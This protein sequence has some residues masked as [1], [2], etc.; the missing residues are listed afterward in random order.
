MV[1]QLQTGGR[2]RV[3]MKSNVWDGK[4]RGDKAIFSR[5]PFT[6][7]LMLSAGGIGMLLPS[8]LSKVLPGLDRIGG[9]IGALS[10]AFWGLFI[11]A[12]IVAAIIIFRQDELAATVVFAVSIVLDF[13]LG[14][15]IV[16]LLMA[17]VLLLIFFLARSPRYPWAEPGALWLWALFLVLII[18]AAIR[19]APSTYEVLYYYSYNTLGT[20]VMFWLGT[21]IARRVTSVRRF[22]NLLAGFGTL[23]AIHAL[24][25][26]TTGIF[27]FWA[28]VNSNYVASLS[29][30]I[31]IP[32]LDVHRVGSFFLNPD[33]A[34]P[35]FAAVLFIA[36]GLFA[37]SAS[38]QG[39]FLY[40]TE[41]SLSA[42]ALLCT[43]TY[44]ALI[45]SGVAIIVLIVLIGRMR[46]RIQL[47]SMLLLFVMVM[48]VYFSDLLQRRYNVGDALIR[49]GAW[50]TALGVIRAFPLTGVGLGLSNYQV[51]AEPYRVAAQ[52][53]PLVQPLNSYLEYGAIGGLPVLLVFVALL[54]FALGL[55]LQNWMRADVQTRA[56]LG[57]CIAAIIALSIDSMTSNVWTFPSLAAM[58]WLIL[59]VISS[60]LL[61]R[62]LNR[63]A[64]KEQNP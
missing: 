17:I 54:L 12:I 53:I 4:L 33:W 55:A 19:G 29:Y 13:Y 44:G 40:F 22:F 3:K 1:K 52:F 26:V 63:Q 8:I 47:S 7:I 6:V 36:L 34:G 62:E 32:G 16:G 50:Q 2:K 18:F 61:S 59:G 49:P 57:G 46:Y 24:V 45:A 38:L 28:S 58:G 64:A 27:L 14:T 25:Q 5:L 51:H 35:F 56:L 23:I 11:G 15:Y 9:S 30:F 39:K 43:Y 48:L 10:P 37:Q 21:V 20:L 41:A 60:P 42:V 31:L